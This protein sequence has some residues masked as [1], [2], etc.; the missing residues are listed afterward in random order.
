[1][2]HINRNKKNI[3]I[4][5]IFALQQKLWFYK[6]KNHNN[7]MGQQNAIRCKICKIC[8]TW[9]HWDAAT[10]QAALPY[11]LGW[12]SEQIFY[13]RWGMIVWVFNKVDVNGCIFDK[14]IH[15]NV[16]VQK[17]KNYSSLNNFK[18]IYFRIKP[19]WIYMFSLFLNLPYY[20]W[21]DCLENE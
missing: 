9:T 13:V 11:I 15:V 14:P 18:W 7:E 2:Y 12:N 1:M 6:L 19:T 10:I 5:I 16:N 4:Q 21:T 20:F 17:W 3:F 8:M